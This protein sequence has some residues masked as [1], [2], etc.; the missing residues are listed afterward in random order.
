MNEEDLIDFTPDLRQ[1]ALEILEDYSIG[2]MF[3]P[4]IH[5]DNDLGKVAAYF[6]PGD[7]GGVNISGPAAA[8]P[9][10]GILYVISINGCSGSRILIPGNEKDAY[11]DQPTGSTIAQWAV[12]DAPGPGG[13][14][15]LPLMKP[16]YSKVTAID[17]NTGEHLW[18]IP[19]GDTPDRILNHPALQ[20]LDIPNTGTGGVGAMIVTGTLLF[21]TGEG[22]DGTP[23]LYFVDKE[24]GERLWSMQIPGNSRY[25]MSTWMH[26]GKQH[27]LI[28]LPDGLA[29]YAL[30]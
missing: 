12:V 10:R 7:G 20:G 19:V 18:W 17:M 21:H 11:L 29:A 24:T 22:S 27:L 6:C 9:V 1:E 15:G 3:N 5:I 16:P 2:P 8:D 28:Q 30:P 13:P 26:E 4:P 23:Y 14:Q 25:G